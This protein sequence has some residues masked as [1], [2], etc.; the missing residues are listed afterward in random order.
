M[1]GKLILDTVDYA[2]PACGG[3]EVRQIDEDT[4]SI[5]QFSNSQATINGAP[6]IIISFVSSSRRNIHRLGCD[7][8]GNEG[9][10]IT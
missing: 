5:A 6:E 2:Y 1:K 9:F 4:I 8:K 3:I 7:Q 10:K